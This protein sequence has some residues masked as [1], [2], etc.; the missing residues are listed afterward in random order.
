MVMK[1]FLILQISLWS[2]IFQTSA[3][4]AQK[5][6][7]MVKWKGLN[8]ANDLVFLYKKGTSYEQKEIFQNN[9]V[10]KPRIDGRGHDPRDGVIDVMLGRI[11]GDYDG[12]IINFS[13]EAPQEQKE[14]LKRAIEESPLVYKVFVD[15]VPGEIKVE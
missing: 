6:N 11:A 10:Y 13:K 3:C 12:G 14:N 15:V 8:D 9:V 7:P 5:E 2:F 1:T 4:T